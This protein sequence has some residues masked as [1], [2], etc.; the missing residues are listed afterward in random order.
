[1]KIISVETLYGFVLQYSVRTHYVNFTSKLTQSEVSRKSSFKVYFHNPKYQFWQR[2][3]EDNKVSVL[4][5][6][7]RNPHD[8]MRISKRH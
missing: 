2:R 1:M 6:L 4:T 5:L 3:T 7:Q 8:I